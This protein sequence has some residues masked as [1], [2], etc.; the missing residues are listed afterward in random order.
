MDRDAALEHLVPLVHEP[1]ERR[2]CE[3]DERQLVRHLEDREGEP[4]SL[5]D[6]ARRDARMLEADPEAET[7]EMAAGQQ[8]NELS[9]ALFVVELDAG[10][11]Q[12]LAAREPRA[13]G[14]AARRCAPSARARRRRPL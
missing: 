3:G 10:G 2:L 12:Q 1:R 11:E 8:P 5:V 14:P 6:H 4:A 13:S 9:L 7:G